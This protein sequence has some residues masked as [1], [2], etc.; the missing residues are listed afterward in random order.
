MTL[1]TFLSVGTLRR[2]T[3]FR[4]FPVFLLAA[5]SGCAHDSCCVRPRC[6]HGCVNET[7]PVAVTPIVVTAVAPVQPL[8]PGLGAVEAPLKFLA[9]G[10]GSQTSYAQYTAGQQKLMAMR[11]AQVDAY[12][13]LAEKV[14]GF[15]VWGSTAVSAFAVQNDSVR[16]YVDSFIR[17]A[18]V[19]NMTAIGDGNFEATVE[20]TLPPDFAEC[21]RLSSLCTTQFPTPHSSPGVI[22]APVV[23]PSVIYTSP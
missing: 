3:L 6:A 23:A 4:L 18:H 13:N 8:S 1:K 10:Y 5:L 11:A 16:T 22:S 19:V 9:V 17:G 20:L 2:A 7:E 21:V 12:R 14:H 15:R